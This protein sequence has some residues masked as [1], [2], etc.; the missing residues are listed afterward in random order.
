MVHVPNYQEFDTYV[1]V[2]LLF[3]V[4]SEEVGCGRVA[5]AP[6]YF[7]CFRLAFIKVI[8]GSVAALFLRCDMGCSLPRRAQLDLSERNLGDD[9]AKGTLAQLR[10]RVRTRALF[11][12]SVP[13]SCFCSRS[14]LPAHDAYSNPEQILWRKAGSSNC[15]AALLRSLTSA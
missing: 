1:T 15:F 8:D 5:L 10:L 6:N 4:R 13:V 14:R 2:D 9:G 12:V 7:L 11:S 3:V